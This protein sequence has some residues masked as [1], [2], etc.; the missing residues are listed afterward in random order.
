MHM[1]KMV[2]VFEEAKELYELLTKPFRI[3]RS[4]FGLDQK[5]GGSDA[6]DS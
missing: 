5:E 1:G 2:S 6:K 4:W 3:I